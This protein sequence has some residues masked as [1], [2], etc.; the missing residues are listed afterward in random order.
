M[1]NADRESVVEQAWLVRELSDRFGLSLED[2]ARR[3]G[4][5]P[6]WVSRRL[7]LAATLPDAIQQLVQSGKLGPHAAMKHL[8]STARSKAWMR[9]SLEKA[10]MTSTSSLTMVA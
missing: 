6:S 4:R 7:G 8:F 10:V 5:S 9:P 3:F 1:R 2:L